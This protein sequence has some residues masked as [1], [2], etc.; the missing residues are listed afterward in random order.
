MN[1]SFEKEKTKKRK[2]EN[3]NEKNVF[4]VVRFQTNTDICS[5]S[6]SWSFKQ[7]RFNAV[8]VFRGKN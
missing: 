4:S 7:I 5:N 2:R 1:S 3:F 6:I 8:L